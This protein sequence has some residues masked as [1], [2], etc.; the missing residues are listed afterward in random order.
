MAEIT[1]P[2]TVSYLP[3]PGLIPITMAIRNIPMVMD[4]Y[5]GIKVI[6]PLFTA[7]IHPTMAIISATMSIFLVT[8]GA[9]YF[10]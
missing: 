8:N 3:Y 4:I 9:V 10:L 5:E 6:N 2:I 1:N 7:I